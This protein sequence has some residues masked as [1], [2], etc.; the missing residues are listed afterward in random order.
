[1]KDTANTGH[2]DGPAGRPQSSTDRKKTTMDHPELP[3]SLPSS[4]EGALRLGGD[5]YQGDP[6]GLFRD[7]RRRHGAV[8]PVLLAWDVP[9]WLV[10]GYS[11]LLQVTCAPELFGR[12]FHRWRLLDLLPPDWP[13]WPLIG[14]GLAT[15]ALIYSEGEEHRRRSAVLNQALARIDQW[16]FEEHCHRSALRLI[17]DFAQKGQTELISSYAQLL[18]VLALGWAVGVPEKDHDALVTGFLQLMGAGGDPAQGMADVERICGEHATRVMATPGNDVASYLA[19]SGLGLTHRQL[20]ADIFIAIIG[21][22]Q[23]C[24]NWIGSTIRLML[25]DQSHTDSLTRGRRS[26]TEAA[27]EVLK[28]DTPTQIYA[29]RWTT[30]STQLAGTAIPAGDLVLLGLAA[31][32]EDPLFRPPGRSKDQH[33]SRAYLSFSHGPH[34]CPHM[35]RPLAESITVSAIETLLT[36]L[37]DLH[38]AVP[39]DQLRWQPQ[40]LIRALEELP[41]DFTPPTQPSDP[42]GDSLWL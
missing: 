25:T 26:V 37:P 17:D 31:A 40:V 20:T 19:Y 38:L 39:A 36:R 29:G 14:G 24:A 23:T 9:A 12:S 30:R 15:D 7:L 1:M 34:G 10:L 22:H 2:Q 42:L 32:H 8:A 13:L 21:G 3:F 28:D 5:M 18:P 4:H 16:E 6:A 33:H 41:I 35:A 11:E 27:R